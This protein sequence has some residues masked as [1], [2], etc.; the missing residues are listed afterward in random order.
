MRKTYKCSNIKFCMEDENQRRTW[1]YL[2]GITRKDGSYGKILS[3]AFVAVLDRQI[4]TGTDK[5]EDNSD[6]AITLREDMDI[7]GKMLDEVLE[8]K[9]NEIFQELQRSL[10]EQIN[11]SF[12]EYASAFHSGAENL[13]EK[14]DADGM[15]QMQ[16]A[17]LSEDMMAFA[18]A[19]GE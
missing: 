19:M 18:F 6:S 1:E 2:Q 10:A 13:T 14:A 11:S 9:F 8:K 12:S 3:D 7:L 4:R 17:E 15:E 5:A 16:E